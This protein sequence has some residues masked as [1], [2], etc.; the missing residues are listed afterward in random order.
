M[1]EYNGA[2]VEVFSSGLTSNYEQLVQG[3]ERMILYMETPS[4]TRARKLRERELALAN[5]VIRRWRTA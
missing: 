4:E 3:V 1:S 2:K 5:L